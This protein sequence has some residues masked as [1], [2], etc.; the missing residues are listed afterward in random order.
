MDYAFD[1]IKSIGGARAIGVVS[2]PYI[3]AI[4]V[5]A[6]LYKKFNENPFNPAFDA[7][8]ITGEFF[9]EF[10]MSNFK[11]YFINLVGFSLGTEVIRSILDTL[12]AKKCLNM[13]HKVYLLGGVA[14][15]LKMERIIQNS[16][17]SL[18]IINL[19]SDC[20][21]VLKYLLRLC[22]SDI[23]PVGL[24]SIKEI[25]GHVIKNVDCS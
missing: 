23:R 14:D 15:K 8:V 13:L 3:T 22:K 16:P 17:V 2:N 6:E 10:L 5:L 25:D 7:A 24:N 20:D 1:S 9:A 11:G 4:A 21:Y 19:H 12:S 18:T